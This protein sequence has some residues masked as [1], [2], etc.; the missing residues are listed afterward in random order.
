MKKIVTLLLVFLITLLSTTS[1]Q[2][3]MGPKP[4]LTIEVIGITEEYYFDVLVDV[5][6]TDE[7]E[8]YDYYT[9]FPDALRNYQDEDGFS[10]YSLYDVPASVK[11]TENNNQSQTYEL[12]YIAPNEFKM[13]IVMKDSNI[14]IKTDVLN[15]K[16]FETDIKWDL[17][18]VDL[19]KAQSGDIGIISGNINGYQTFFES[20]GYKTAINSFIRLLVTIIVEVAIL[21][22]FNI[23]TKKAITLVVIVNAIT[24]LF[25]GTLLI[26][27]Y[28]TSGA[29]AFVFMT[30]VLELVVLLFEL[31]VY[32][33]KLK[34][35]SMIKIVLYTIL[36]NA[37]TFIL[38]ILLMT[39]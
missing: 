28:L 26:S 7:E 1:V 14:I 16:A 13:V 22:A 8:P 23:K 32:S 3:D 18:N 25:I 6:P 19:T 35:I 4:S 33:V 12:N 30:I 31:V 9:D 29:L 39:V 17:S 24:N 5:D 27:I 20:V 11:Q 10:S 2:A 36:A 34:E 21:L 37:V 38:G 15:A